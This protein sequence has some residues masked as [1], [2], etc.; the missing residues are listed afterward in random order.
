MISFSV[1]IWFSLHFLAAETFSSS[2]FSHRRRWFLLPALGRLIFLIDFADIMA[3][4]LI[5]DFLIFTNISIFSLSFS[6]DD[7]WCEDWCRSIFFISFLRCIIIFF[8][9]CRFLDYF[10]LLSFSSA[11]YFLVVSIFFRYITPISFS[12][13]GWCK[14]YFISFH[15]YISF[16]RCGFDAI[17]SFFQRFR[18]RQP[19]SLFFDEADWF[20][21]SSMI[22][23]YFSRRW[24]FSAG[25]IFSR[26]FHFFDLIF[27]R[28]FRF[29][30]LIFF[31]SIFISIIFIFRLLSFSFFHFVSFRWGNYFLS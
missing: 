13:L 22:F 24:L 4:A 26:L 28:L 11:E 5:I 1:N 17:I 12:I 21:S 7:F 23:R 10:R 16:F 18:L 27:L 30:S 29:L 25:K 14:Y 2:T 8:L 31:P 6:A 20:L 19:F 9:F 3:V 15:W